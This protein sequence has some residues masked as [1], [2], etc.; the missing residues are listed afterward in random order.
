MIEHDISWIDWIKTLWPVAT[1]LAAFG[2]RVEVGQA[3]NRAAIR[4][5]KSQRQEDKDD[6][7]DMLKEV[8]TD[9]REIRDLLT[10]PN[11]S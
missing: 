6:M 8:R 3:L 9:V 5:L 11:N 4:E 1:V 10:R 7:R 2:V